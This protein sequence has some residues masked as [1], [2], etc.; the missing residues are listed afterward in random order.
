MVTAIKFSPDYKYVVAFMNDV[1][2]RKAIFMSVLN[3]VNGT[4][5]RSIKDS[6]GKEAEVH[7]E[8]LWFQP[9]TYDLIL[10]ARM[11]SGSTKWMVMRFNPFYLALNP[12]V[13]SVNPTF[14][15]VN[16]NSDASSTAGALS[17]IPN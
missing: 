6:S 8:S 14:A 10:G 4:L 9:T 16:S 1:N 2:Y 15:F 17:I 5:I 13:T 11:G 7:T 3:A 12:A